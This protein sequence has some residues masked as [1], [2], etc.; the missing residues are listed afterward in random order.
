VGAEKLEK[1]RMLTMGEREELRLANEAR[2]SAR[3]PLI[4]VK[5]RSCL[6]CRT[7]FESIGEWTCGCPSASYEPEG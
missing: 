2:A 3:L 5:V 1:V 6:R 4:V 7:R